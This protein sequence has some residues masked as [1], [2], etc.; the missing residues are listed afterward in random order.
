M[1]SPMSTPSKSRRVFGRS[2]CWLLMAGLF[3]SHF[4]FSWL[5]YGVRSETRDFEQKRGL[6]AQATGRLTLSV[7]NLEVPERWKFFA[8]RLDERKFKICVA[9]EEIDRWPRSDNMIQTYARTHSYESDDRVELSSFEINGYFARDEPS[10]RFVCDSGFQA[11]LTLPSDHPLHQRPFDDLIVEVLPDPPSA[12]EPDLPRLLLRVIDPRTPG[13]G[14]VMW[15][16]ERDADPRL[17]E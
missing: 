15:I 2:L 16:E 11:S 3:A 14:L 7:V 4:Y 12:N 1:K 9:C 17:G 13:R 5:L 8:E 6:V 10:T